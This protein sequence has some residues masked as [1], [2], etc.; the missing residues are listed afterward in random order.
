MI[1]DIRRKTTYDVLR[2]V[3]IRKQHAHLMLKE[4]DLESHDQ[5][6]VTAFVYTCLQHHLWV[7][8]QLEDLVDERTPEEVMILLKMGVCQWFKMD[9]IPDYALVNETVNLAVAVGK[10]RYKGLINAV[11]KKVI[12]RGLRPIGLDGLA[13]IAIECSIPL[14]ILKLLAT[15]HGE[16]WAIAYAHYCQLIKPVYIRLN[17]LVD[18]QAVLGDVEWVK[19]AYQAKPGFFTKDHLDH[20]RCTVQDK[21]S[22]Q[23]VSYLDLHHDQAVLDCCCGPGTKSVAI[24]DAM[25]NTGS[26]VGVELHSRRLAAVESLL[27]RCNVTN[28]NL[29]L[30]DARTYGSDS[31]FDRMLIDAPC[32]GLGVLSHKYDLRFTLEPRH[33]DELQKLQE[34]ILNNMSQYVKVKGILVYA[35][36]TLNKKENERQI[37]KFLRNN[38]HYTLLQQVTLDPIS[39]QGDGFY[40]AQCQRTW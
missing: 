10:G 39:T 40:I 12:A 28:A 20:G 38:P 16:D 32:S 17:G 14:W 26:L 23:V 25:N 31:L 3:L 9:A 33:L 21:N 8:Y 1:I 18:H 13:R 34:D 6:F 4:L 29:V 15:Q 2:S 7:S 36:C 19:D 22:Q 11:L 27:Q 37:E 5:A 24:A 35:T 30:D